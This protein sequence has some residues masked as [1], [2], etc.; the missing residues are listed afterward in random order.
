MHGQAAPVHRAVG[1]GRGNIDGDTR[2]VGLR[3]IGGKGVLPLVF[4]RVAYPVVPESAAFVHVGRQGEILRQEAAPCICQQQLRSACWSLLAAQG[5]RACLFF[6]KEELARVFAA[7][8]A[9]H[10]EEAAEIV[11]SG[12]GAAVVL[13]RCDTIVSLGCQSETGYSLR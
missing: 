12:R 4:Q 8:K 2:G 10:V 6:R 1:A 11:H 13:Q 9:A 3:P 7:D 5:K